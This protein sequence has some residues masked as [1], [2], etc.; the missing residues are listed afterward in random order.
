MA[1]FE[2]AVGR[3]LCGRFPSI[4][5][6]GEGALVQRQKLGGGN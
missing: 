4:E 1:V 5:Q 2:S 6:I 3:Q